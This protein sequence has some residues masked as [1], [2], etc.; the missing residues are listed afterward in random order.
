[1]PHEH[2]PG[3]RPDLS[4]RL[5]ATDRA[6][7]GGEGPARI[8]PAVASATDGVLDPEDAAVYDKLKERRRERRRKTLR[9]RAIAGG[10]AVLVVILAVL[11]VSLLTRTPEQEALAVT[12]VAMRGTYA[13]TVDASGTLEPLSSTV[14]TPE[15]EGTIAEVRV[16]AG[17]SVKKGDVVLTV[18]NDELDRAIESARRDL[19]DAQAELSGAKDAEAEAERAYYADEVGEV[20]V[21]TVNSA[22]DAVNA[23]SRAVE[24]ARE[25]YDQAVATAAKRT[26]TAPADGSVVALNAQVGARVGGG[27]GPDGTKPLV[28]IAD[29]TQ[30]KVTVQ[31]DEESISKIAKDQQAVITFPAFSDALVSGRVVGIASVASNGGEAG[32]YYGEGAPVTFAVDVLIPEP[33]P[34]LKPGMTANVS[35]TVEKIDDV[36]MVPVT[37]LQTDGGESYHVVVETDPETHAVER[38]D[39]TV[40]TQND[41]YAVVGRPE[42][43]TGDME[44]S[45][46]ADGETLVISGGG[47]DAMDGA[48]LEGEPG[49]GAA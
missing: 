35:L 44:V 37:A 29:L 16:S 38:R 32:G 17:Q 23:A 30:M 13:T 26:V 15:V 22:I 31:V 46:V 12:D 25:A 34:R 45:P 18:K 49:G 1:M 47:M 10:V 8:L 5:P 28:Q 36:I 27:A 4:D 3:I 9:R 48:G 11:A 20:P 19:Q 43:G 2:E 42:D 21:E 39:V 33:D 41:D 40:I 7:K 24:K 14:I 6:P